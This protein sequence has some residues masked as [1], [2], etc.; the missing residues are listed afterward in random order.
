MTARLGSLCT[1]MGGLDL[2]VAAVLDVD[3]AWHAE[4]DPAA[5]KVLA[6]HW[7]EVPNLGDITTVDWTAVERVDVLTGGVP[8]QSYSAAGKRLGSEDDRDLWPVRKH[9]PDG[10]PRRG[11]LDCIRELRPTLFVFENVANLLSIQGGL[12]FGTILADLDALGYTVSWATVGACRVGACHHR[13]RIFLAATLADVDPPR[14]EPV[15]HLAGDRWE[16]LQNVLFGDA[17]AVRWPAAGMTR[18]GVVWPLRAQACG[19]VGVVLPTPTAADG[20]SGPGHAR[21]SQGS[22]DL[23]TVV[24]LLP[25]PRAVDGTSGQ[26]TLID[27]RTAGDRGPRLSDIASLLPTPTARDATRGAGWGDQSGRPLSEVIA[28]LPST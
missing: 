5:A 12:P 6:A 16:P 22:P 7:P 11:A 4:A 1:G 15:A 17:K 18:A 14:G 23:R 20:T 2:A 9:E 3:H 24:S 26:Q 25:T 10:T 27:G 21:S 28:L 13:H 8:C 19:A